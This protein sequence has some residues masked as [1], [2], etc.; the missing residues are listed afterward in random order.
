M[1]NEID[2]EKAIDRTQ[3]WMSGKIGTKL[4]T[5]LKVKKKNN[6]MIQ[7][8]KNKNKKEKKQANLMTRRAVGKEK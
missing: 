4:S 1:L 5:R 6:N 7:M 2:K 8:E 3:G